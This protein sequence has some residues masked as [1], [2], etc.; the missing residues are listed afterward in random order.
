[1]V[2][3]VRTATLLGVDA[4][5][6]EVETELSQGL[7]YFSII[8]LGDAAVQE[9]RYRIQAALRATGLDLPHKRI[10]VNLAPAALRKDG[11]ALD[12][13]MALGLLVAAGH[14]PVEAL[15]GSLALGE[16]ALSGAVRPV[17]GSLSVAALARALGATRVIAPAEN[18]S[19]AGAIHGIEVIPAHS[20]G[21]LVAILR[22]EGAPQ[23]LPARRPQVRRD[24]AD[25]AE[26]RGQ[27]LPRRALEVAAAGGHNL[28]LVGN[29]GSGKTMLARRLPSILPDLT[30]DEQIEVT[31]VWSAAGLTIGR[32]G[33]LE[34]RPFRAPHHTISEAGLIGGGSSVRPGEVSLAHQGVLFLDEMPELP[35]RVLESLR[36]PLED[37]E[38]VIARARHV[39]RLPAAF[40]LIGAANPCPCGWLGHRS[41][42]CWC[43]PE[44]V[45]RYASRISGALLDRIDLVVEAPSLNAEE[46]MSDA[47]GEPSATVRGRVVA[48]RDRA[49]SRSGRPNAQLSGRLLSKHAAMGSAARSLLA[50]SIERLQLSARSMERTLRVARTI[51]DL[52]GREH[53]QDTHLAEALR[54]RQPATW[55]GAPV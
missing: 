27:R 47:T 22:G 30:P 44:E 18:A 32:D 42:R 40:M 29:P 23:P 49:L 28:L 11:A 3:V 14:V 6:V 21:E 16:L 36:Q 37:K 9:A 41:G 24:E 50:S 43:T 53:L 26:V 19:E 13:P 35:R 52:E 7:P 5:L 10:T 12:L 46:L 2:A 33:L 51:A 45:Q 54:Y 48:A 15:A 4:R 55:S 1:M 39:V 38:V 25:L 20:L 31:K 8:G 17:R 34:A